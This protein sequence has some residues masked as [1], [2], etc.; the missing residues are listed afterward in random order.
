MKFDEAFKKTG[1]IDSARCAKCHGAYRRTF[2]DGR[3]EKSLGNGYFS[4]K[5]EVAIPDPKIEAS[6]QAVATAVH[7]A[8]LL[9]TEAK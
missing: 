8:I 6:Y 1:E 7:K 4:S 9:A 2:R 5:L 3:L